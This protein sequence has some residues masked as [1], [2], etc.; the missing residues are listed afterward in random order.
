MTTQRRGRARSGGRK[1]TN[2]RVWVN[3]A[4][5][6]S[7]TINTN[8]LMIALTDALPFMLFDSTILSF[9]I[10]GLD[11]S[12]TTPAATA[13]LREGSVNFFVARDTFDAADLVLSPGASGIGPRYLWTGYTSEVIDASQ[14]PWN[15]ALVPPGGIRV[16]SMARFT[17]NEMTLFMA[18]R[19]N[20][21]ASDATAAFNGFMRTLLLVP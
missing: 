18:M 9:H 1:R 5:A 2:R 13:G 12:I 4:I 3:K 7:V 15:K 6:E 16:K 19:M 10:V 11:A 17:E 21:N 14:A 20:G 8:V